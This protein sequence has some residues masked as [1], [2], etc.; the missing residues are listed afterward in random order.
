M[1]GD[2]AA[3]SAID[4]AIPHEFDAVVMRALA[5]RPDARFPSMRAFGSALLSVADRAAWKR[6]AAEFAGVDPTADGAPSTETAD[7]MVRPIA[8]IAHRQRPARRW[9]AG[10]LSA[11]AVAAV[12]ALGTRLIVRGQAST[13]SSRAS[14]PLVRSA[15][16]AKPQTAPPPSPPPPTAAPATTATELPVPARRPAARRQKPPR[17]A[18]ALAPAGA[19]TLYVNASPDWAT[20]SIDGT[21][22]G[23]TPTVLSDVPAGPHTLVVRALGRAPSLQRSVTVEPGGTARVEFDFAKH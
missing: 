12:T 8:P 11:L 10:A 6:W 13:P 1:T 19:G 20:V 3:P 17:A 18:P 4:P 14:T 16:V 23:T 7:D 5:R 22:A 2:L 21:P 9:L 15:P